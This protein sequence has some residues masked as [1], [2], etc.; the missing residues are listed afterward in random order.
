MIA[1]VKKIKVL[2]IDDHPLFR[3]GMISILEKYEIIEKIFEASDITTADDCNLTDGLRIF[4]RG[5]RN[6]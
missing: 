2:I 4:I 1:M 3:K 6:F 5:L